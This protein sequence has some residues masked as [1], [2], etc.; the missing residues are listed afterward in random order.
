MDA[1]YV[2]LSVLRVYR[3][4]EQGDVGLK[5]NGSS[6]GGSCEES[7]AARRDCVGR[8][9]VLGIIHTSLVKFLKET[10]RA[11]GLGP[12]HPL[13]GRARVIDFPCCL[14][15]RDSTRTFYTSPQ[16][17]ASIRTRFASQIVSRLK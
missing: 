1:T 3:K 10:L 15:T 6:G 11:D 5:E 9:I 12:S 8:S 4:V 16:L 17:L 13:H 2:V 7:I 14:N